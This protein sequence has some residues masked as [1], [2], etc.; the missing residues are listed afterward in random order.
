MNIDSLLGTSKRWIAATALLTSA[1]AAYGGPLTLTPSA[2]SVAPGGSFSVTLSYLSANA[3][4]LGMDFTVDASPSAATPH[5][6]LMAIQSL[7]G[8][9]ANASIVANPMLPG[10]VPSLVSLA[11]DAPIGGDSL[12]HDLLRFDFLLDGTTPT[13]YVDF[14]LLNGLAFTAVGVDL[15]FQE[16]AR[17]D[18][19]TIPEGNSLITVLIGLAALA[20]AWRT[21]STGAL[22]EAATVPARR[23]RFGN[24]QDREGHRSS[25]DLT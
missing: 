1:L 19:T 17:L 14:A 15:N 20:W 12:A 8:S 4:E 2:T 5:V 18:V 22:L 9:I 23:R 11:I 7:I 3:L 16:T 10:A 13:G 6:T 21:G 25:I 24:G